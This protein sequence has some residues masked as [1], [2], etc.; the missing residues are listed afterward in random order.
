ME[1]RREANDKMKS[2]HEPEKTKFFLKPQINDGRS[3]VQ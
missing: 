1:Q 2:K 3:N